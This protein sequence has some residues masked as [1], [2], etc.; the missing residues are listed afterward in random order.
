L[1][2]PLDKLMHSAGG[3][4]GHEASAS[5]PAAS[6]PAAGGARADGSSDSRSRDVVRDRERGE[7]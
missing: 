4:G 6:A 3:Q 5:A 1:Y 7:R 2:L